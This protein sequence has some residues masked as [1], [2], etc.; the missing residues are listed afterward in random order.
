MRHDELHIFRGMR[1]DLASSKYPSD[2]LIDANNI[3]MILNG[4]E[5]SLSI[6]NEKGSLDTGITYSGTYL[7]HCVLG[8]FVVVFTNNDGTNYIYRTDIAHNNQTIVLFSGS[9]HMTDLIETIPSYETYTIQ[10]VYWLDGT[11]SLRYINIVK[12][13]LID[14]EDWDDSKTY[15]ENLGY[16]ET[17]FEAT[18]ASLALDEEMTVTRSQNSAGNFPAGVIQYAFSYTSRYGRESPIIQM[19]PLYG[20]AYDDRAGSPDERVQ[21]AFTINISNVDT[22]QEYLRLYSIERTSLDG[23]PIVKRI[24]DS[25]IEGETYTF[26]YTDTGNTGSE[27]DESSLL[28]TSIS[29]GATAYTM[30][31]KDNTLF[32]GNIKL[33]GGSSVPDISRSIKTYFGSNDRTRQSFPAPIQGVQTYLIQHVINQQTVSSL[34]PPPSVYS[35]IIP[36]VAKHPY[37]KNNEYYRCGLQFQYGNGVWTNPVWIGDY[38]V[39]SDAQTGI[40]VN[41]EDTGETNQVDYGEL[42]GTL[43]EHVYN[44]TTTFKGLGI[45]V[46][47]PNSIISNAISQGYKRI[48][49]VIVSPSPTDRTIMAQGIINPAMK[50]HTSSNTYCYRN[51]WFTRPIGGDFMYQ[52][53]DKLSK[54]KLT[55]DTSSGAIK[56]NSNLEIQGNNDSFE[57]TYDV[58]TFNSPD[59]EQDTVFQGSRIVGNCRLMGTV[60]QVSSYMYGGWQLST[61]PAIGGSVYSGNREVSQLLAEHNYTFLDYWIDQ[62]LNGTYGQWGPYTWNFLVYPWQRSGSMNN[63]IPRGQ[64]QTAV[65]KKKQFS[66]FR[67]F[68]D[69]TRVSAVSCSL[70]EDSRFFN[71]TE[72]TDAIN[73]GQTQLYYGNTDTAVQNSGGKYIG[74]SHWWYYDNGVEFSDTFGSVSNNTSTGILKYISSYP[75]GNDDY[76]ISNSGSDYFFKKGKYSTTRI[77]SND[78]GYDPQPG[79]SNN[80]F[81]EMIDSVHITSKCTPHVVLHPTSVIDLNTFSGNKPRLIVAELYRSYDKNTIF[82]GTSDSAVQNNVWIVASKSQKLAE[83]NGDTD[84]IFEYGDTWLGSYQCM[85]SQPLTDQDINQNTDVAQFPCESRVNLYGRYDTNGQKKEFTAVSSANFNLF[86]PV[87]NQLDNYFTYRVLDDDYDREGNQRFPTQITWSLQKTAGS[88]DDPWTQIQLASVFD[89]DGSKGEIVALRTWNDSI[90]CFQE[91]GISVIIFNPRVAIPTSDGVPIEI[92]NS[93]KLEGRKYIGDEI[94]VVNKESIVVTQNGIYFID[95]VSGD[96]YHI[97]E[98]LE[99]LSIKYGMSSWIRAQDLNACKANSYTSKSFYDSRNQDYYFTTTQKTLGFSE[100]LQAFQSFYSYKGVD[101]L[102]SVGNKCYAI[103]GGKLW[104]MFSGV[105]GS[106]MGDTQP[107]NISF[108]SNGLNQNLVQADKIF[109]NID[110]RMDIYNGNTLTNNSFDLLRVTDEY[111]DTGEVQLSYL[112][113]HPSNLKKKFREWRV[114]I[115]RD[116]THRMDRIRNTWAKVFLGVSSSNASKRAILHDVNVTYYT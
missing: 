97:G 23:T 116:K 33:A 89:L 99:N 19:S 100:N 77:C 91:R 39:Q 24:I 74:T 111:Q 108:I 103:K 80:A 18:S 78:Q 115:P 7:G 81:N 83:I 69:F 107:W 27:V 94:G 85:R 28:F 106:Y 90:Y 112:N 26:S 47:V 8:D 76:V 92:S 68:S 66:F 1:Q 43:T 79:K 15:Q 17:S 6:T 16:N 51:S 95:S 105:Y 30:C 46:T 12:E 49:A 35:G 29:G 75:S 14:P 60:D 20:V 104:S 22:S 10:K 113:T 70:A 11:N 5:A 13:R 42:V 72:S 50:E 61:P 52:H 2:F 64:D 55:F 32:L 58:L 54:G 86:N 84:V 73:I 98:S 57:V 82:G 71:G 96:L 102:F 114:Q 40:I 109:S 3:R 9:L 56:I 36:E 67:V 34:A 4:E 65:L 31:Q 59:I 21:C 38:Q 93:Y 63:D 101:A 62:R 87:Y 88:Q 110:Y 37:F 44:V 41:V 53:Q 48:R 45:K 25:K